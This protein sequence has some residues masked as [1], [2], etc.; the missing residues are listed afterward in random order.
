MRNLLFTVIATC[1]LLGRLDGHA[2]R[3]RPNPMILTFGGPDGTIAIVLTGDE[4]SPN[5]AVFASAN[6]QPGT[7][8]ALVSVTSAGP[9]PAQPQF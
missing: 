9:N 6:P 8:P 7:G 2:V 1:F 5:C 4:P 3:Y